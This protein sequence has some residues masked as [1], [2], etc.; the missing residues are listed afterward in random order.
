[1]MDNEIESMLDGVSLWDNN[2]A[3]GMPA[4]LWTTTLGSDALF[5]QYEA[6]P[7]AANDDCY[8]NLYP[9]IA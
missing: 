6:V 9:F 2:P 5:E 7:S 1:M 8:E 4:C 3:D